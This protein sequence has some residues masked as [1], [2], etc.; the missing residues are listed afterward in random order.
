M[1]TQ[2]TLRARRGT[3]WR[4]LLGV[5]AI[6][7]AAVACDGATEPNVPEPS[8]P[9][10]LIPATPVPA[11]PEPPGQPAKIIKIAGD[12]QTGRPGDLRQLIVAVQDTSGKSVPGVR[13]R[14]SVTAGDGLVYGDVFTD[15]TG[16]VHELWCL[17]RQGEN[18]LL[19]TVEGEGK[20]LEVT[21]RA[22]SVFSGY[23]GGSFALT[24]TGM[25]LKLSGGWFLFDCVVKSGSVVLSPDGYFVGTRDVDC[26]YEDD[27]RE[28]HAYSIDVSETGFY[29]VSGST[30][31]LHYL[32]S[33]DTA[34]IFRL[35]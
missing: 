19:A 28:S 18:T 29:A 11:P 32:K 31:V 25:S 7:A 13:V 14:F 3:A 8:L 6:S 2:D 27:A 5:V 12:D 20:P 15:G 22:T 24:S 33:N 35:P 26:V 30:I 17:G 21:F 34:G 1:N 16:Q 9:A 10:P 4:A 23:A